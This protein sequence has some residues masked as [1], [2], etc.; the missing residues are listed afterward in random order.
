MIIL[1]LLML[2][3]GTAFA[4]EVITGFDDKDDLPVLNET[5]RELD[6]KS[7]DLSDMLEAGTSGQV[8]TSTG[9]NSEPTYQT[10]AQA[11]TQAEQEADSSTTTYVSP[12]RAEYHP[13]S[14]KAWAMFDG[15]TVGTHAPTV[16]YNITSVTRNGT[17]DYTITWATDFS[18]ANYVISCTVTAYQCGITTQAAGTAQLSTTISD[19]T[20][21]DMAVVSVVAYGD[22]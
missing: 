8:L 2:F 11:A 7:I 4:G 9:D 21:T 3:Q 18:T 16:G 19:G 10:P 6:K 13:S 12:G 14:A 17:G 5:L 15:T 1:V 22:Q 20:S